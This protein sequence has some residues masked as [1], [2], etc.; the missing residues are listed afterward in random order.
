MSDWALPQD[1]PPGEPAPASSPASPSS[2]APAGRPSLLIVGGGFAAVSL[3]RKVD[4]RR[5]AVTVVSKRNHFLF[6][7][8]LPSSTVGTVEF[9]SIIDPIR[10][11]R[12]EGAA[13]F[14]QASAKRLDPASRRLYCR[15]DDS[16]AEFELPYDVLVIAVGSLSSTLGVP[17]VREHALF[18]KELTDA[19]RLRERII[20]VLERAT[21]PGIDPAERGRLLHFAVVGGGPTGVEFAAE[22]YDLLVENVPRS[23]PDLASLVKITLFDALPTILGSFDEELREY[24]MRSFSRRGIEVRL[25]SPV[26]AVGD[27]WLR[28]RGGEVVAAGTVVWCSGV[29]ATPF[30]GGLPFDRD[31][32]GRLIVDPWLRVGGQGDVYAAGDCAAIEG[33]VLPLTAQVAMQQ[34]K[35]L[36]RA[37]ADR[38]RGREPKPFAFK[39]LGMLAYVG[40][41]QALAEIPAAKVRW[42]G[43]LA[44]VFWRSAYLTRLVSFKNKVLVLF[45]WLKAAVFG[46]DLSR[47]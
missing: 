21:V 44:Y 34:G 23:Y 46:R 18:L 35:Y 10:R 14:L 9:R 3:L 40:D 7:P 15:E 16:G 4:V 30:V 38:A 43:A 25:E 28:L 31:R 11:V 6:T 33:N 29:A 22:L 36:A 26:E 37:L 41:Q 45:D 39:N 32:A 27:G 13:R 1:P 5:Y 42:R 2:S 24:T 19:R 17:G 20:A 8:L 47:F 12:R